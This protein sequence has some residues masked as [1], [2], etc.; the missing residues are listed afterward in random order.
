MSADPK[1]NP[2]ILIQAFCFLADG[3]V[4]VEV[5]C[6]SRDLPQIVLRSASRGAGGD[7][8]PLIRWRF[9]CY[10]VG[11]VNIPDERELIPTVG[12]ASEAALHVF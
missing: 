2:K 12:L 6:F 5:T 7:E 11:P 4:T 1:L 3:Q 10:D 9:I 8:L